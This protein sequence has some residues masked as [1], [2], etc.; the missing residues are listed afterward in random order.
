[1]PSGTGLLLV[2][3]V[4]IHVIYMNSQKLDQMN[5]REPKFLC[6]S[7]IRKVGVFWNRMLRFSYLSDLKI[8]IRV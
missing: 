8:I 3:L 1:M 6:I 7:S 5:L 2:C 4:S